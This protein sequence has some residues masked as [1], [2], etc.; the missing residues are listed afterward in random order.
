[1]VAL[2][3]SLIQ[4][5]LDIGNQVK[6]KFGMFV[7]IGIVGIFTLQVVI[8]IGMV[9]GLFPIVGITLPFISYGRSSF[10]IFVVMMGFLLNLSK[11]RTMF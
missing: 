11:R 5:S 3:F 9:M 2:Y 10:L 7:T 4:V 8:N 6:D 1:L